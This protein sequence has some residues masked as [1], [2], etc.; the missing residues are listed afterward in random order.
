V[1]EEE[2]VL[3]RQIK[4]DLPRT[5]AGSLWE[6]FQH[7]TLQEMMERI[8]FIWAVRHPACGYVQGIN[9]LLTPFLVVFMAAE[10]DVALFSELDVE[11]LAS[12]EGD[13]L[14]NIEADAYYCFTKILDSIQDHYTSGQPGIQRMV[15]N[16][17]NIIRRIDPDL[18][19]HLQDEGCSFLQFSF[20]WFNCLLARE[21]PIEC[22]IR[23]W[24][25]YIAE[26]RDYGGSSLYGSDASNRP[27]IPTNTSSFAAFHTYVCAVFLMYWGSQLKRMAFQELTMFMQRLP[28]ARWSVYDIETLLSEAYVM[29]TKFGGAPC[30]FAV[31]DGPSNG[32]NG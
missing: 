9:D 20:R 10:Q 5:N 8:L 4:V 11:K 22:V 16:L 30:H 2:Q 7:P 32:P 13:I 14:G 1:A 26:S 21:F 17:S 3:I 12:M 6:L 29:Q 15:M 19:K 31:S 18:H 24:D 23:L 27:S 25:T 28:T